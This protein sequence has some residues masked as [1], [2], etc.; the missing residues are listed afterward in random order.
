[1]LTAAVGDKVKRTVVASATWSG[2]LVGGGVVVVVV[3][4]HM[5]LLV[6]M[7]ATTE[8][9]GAGLLLLLLL[10]LKGRGSTVGAALLRRLKDEPL[11][12]VLHHLALAG[13]L[14]GDRPLLDR[15][16]Q[17][18]VLRVEDVALDQLQGAGPGGQPLV[19]VVGQAGL[20]QPALLLVGARVEG[21]L[22]LEDVLLNQLIPRRPPLNLVLQVVAGLR[23]LQLQPLLVEGGRGFG[24]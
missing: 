16:L 9:G 6:M 19:E 23:P 12:R 11:R 18:P 4:G 24:R 21:G 5:L 2:Q 1:M 7:K 8:N 17:R 14:E 13:L 3:A 10:L 15:L 20:L 22:L